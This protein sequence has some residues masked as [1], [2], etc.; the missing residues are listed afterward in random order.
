MLS[1]RGGSGR[2]SAAHDSLPKLPSLS[3]HPL[4]HCWVHGHGSS[5]ATPVLTASQIRTKENGSDRDAAAQD[6]LRKRPCTLS[7]AQRYSPSDGLPHP[8]PPPHYCLEDMAMAHHFRD[9]YRHGDPRELREHYRHIGEHLAGRCLC[10]WEHCAA[11][12]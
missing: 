8:V 10:P 3:G 5:Q 2:W 6:P 12:G 1:P 9:P 4:A 7:P 11:C